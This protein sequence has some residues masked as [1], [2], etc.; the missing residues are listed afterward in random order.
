MNANSQDLEVNSY[1]KVRT[2]GSKWRPVQQNLYDLAQ[3]IIPQTAFADPHSF[4]SQMVDEPEDILKLLLDISCNNNPHELADI[5]LGD[6]SISVKRISGALIV[7]I[8][9]PM[10]T[11]AG[12]A[13]A[14]AVT[15]HAQNG[16]NHVKCITF[17][18]GRL[19]ESCFVCEVSANGSHT[20]YGCVSL[21]SLLREEDYIALAYD[22]ITIDR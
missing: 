11:N 22:R 21:D 1:I 6:F 20:N 9:F 8:L 4:I 19:S 17:E 15:L 2:G 10:P 12:E 18:R 16:S 3:H 14:I 13:Y 5:D 7:L